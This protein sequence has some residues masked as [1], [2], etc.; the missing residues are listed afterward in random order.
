MSV[1]GRSFIVP[2]PRM[3][4]ERTRARPAAAANDRSGC[5]RLLGFYDGE[6]NVLWLFEGGLLEIWEGTYSGGK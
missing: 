1:R 4:P 6:A 3:H 2:N 5:P